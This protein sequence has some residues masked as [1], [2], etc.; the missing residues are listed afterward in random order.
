MHEAAFRTHTISLSSFSSGSTFVL[1]RLDI[2]SG[3]YVAMAGERSEK[4]YVE[5]CKHGGKVEVKMHWS[6]NGNHSK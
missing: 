1:F 6:K 4:V 3:V 2:F 5:L